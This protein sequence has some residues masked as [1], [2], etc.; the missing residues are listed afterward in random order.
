MNEVVNMNFFDGF[1]SQSHLENP[2]E[3]LDKITR[4]L[5]LGRAAMIREVSSRF[6]TINDNYEHI[7]EMASRDREN[8][9]LEL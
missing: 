3:N 9:N 4:K 6:E 8:G 7:Q 2:C 5:P 1:P